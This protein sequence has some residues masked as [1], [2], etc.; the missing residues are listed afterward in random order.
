M[1]DDG[2]PT[3]SKSGLSLYFRSTRPGGSGGSDLWVAQ[4]DS[5]D[6]PW[7]APVNLG[8]TVNSSPNEACTVLSPDEH[9]MVFVSD[10]PEGGCGGYDLWLTHRQNKRDDFGPD[11]RNRARPDVAGAEPPTRS[12]LSR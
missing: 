6:D 1:Q 5:L 12:G 9:W 10:R 11:S 4:R 8:S 3:L 7:D 2:N